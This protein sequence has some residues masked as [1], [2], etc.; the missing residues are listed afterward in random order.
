MH[1]TAEE[2]KIH[3][4]IPISL[5]CINKKCTT[6]P[7]LCYIC[8]ETHPNHQL[9]TKEIFSKRLLLEFQENLR[10]IKFQLENI[11]FELSIPPI[12]LL[13]S[14]TKQYYYELKANILAII[15]KEFKHKLRKL[16]EIRKENKIKSSALMKEK[17]K[18]LEKNFGAFQNKILSLVKEYEDGKLLI[19]NNLWKNLEFQMNLIDQEINILQEH[20]RAETEQNIK[21]VEKGMM[22]DI[23][24][25]SETISM[26]IDEFNIKWSKKYYKNR[27]N[28]RNIRNSQI[29]KKFY[30]P[31]RN[32]GLSCIYCNKGIKKE[33]TNY[34]KLNCSHILHYEC[35]QHQITS[36]IQSIC[37]ECRIEI[38]EEELGIIS[39]IRGA[40][41]KYQLPMKLLNRGHEISNNPIFCGECNNQIELSGHKIR[42]MDYVMFHCLCHF[43]RSCIAHLDL[44]PGNNCP[45]CPL[46]LTA[47]DLNI[48]LKIRNLKIIIPPDT[49]KE[50]NLNK[51]KSE[52]R[53]ERSKR[54]GSLGNWKANTYISDRCK[55][56]P[57]EEEMKENAIDNSSVSVI[58]NYIYIYI[59]IHR[60]E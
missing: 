50:F 22:E 16:D 43:H 19:K 33:E 2:C 46:K 31:K 4:G 37:P 3:K 18:Q 5:V 30:D 13:I 57:I 23:S 14:F 21:E 27:N 48:I 9:L 10:G 25:D 44:A 56:I 12:E 60:R 28:I 32:E 26:F 54:A 29:Q 49:R 36:P 59:Y 45:V 34:L 55:Q 53:Y 42:N 24:M 15:D 58:G 1:S 38:G 52:N 6:L 41:N 8:S 47:S 35:I 17:R 7:E 51:I 11:K 39:D 20:Q 40:S